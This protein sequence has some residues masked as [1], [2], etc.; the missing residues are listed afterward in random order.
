VRSD[1][2]PIKPKEATNKNYR[3]ISIQEIDSRT[4]NTQHTNQKRSIA[5]IIESVCLSPS[6]NLQDNVDEEIEYSNKY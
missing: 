1:L 2:P 3:G 4:T 5:H 6:S